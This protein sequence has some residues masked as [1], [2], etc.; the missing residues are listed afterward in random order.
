M[1]VTTRV[2]RPFSIT[3]HP[4]L[5]ARGLVSCGVVN[6][7][8]TTSVHPLPCTLV[9]L[10]SRPHPRNGSSTTDVVQ[11]YIEH[12]YARYLGRAAYRLGTAYAQKTALR[13][14]TN[15]ANSYFFPKKTR[16]TTR[17]GSRAQT[18]M[19]KRIGYGRRS[20]YGARRRTAYRRPA[21]R[22]RSARRTGGSR[23]R[24][25]GVKSRLRSGRRAPGYGHPNPR[26]RARFPRGYGSLTLRRNYGQRAAVTYHPAIHDANVVEP[27]STS[28]LA[29]VKV[30]GTT[31]DAFHLFGDAIIP[32]KTVIGG[33]GRDSTSTSVLFHRIR[34]I[35]TTPTPA[36]EKE[37]EVRWI[38]VRRNVEHDQS[39]LWHG[40]V[41][42]S[43]VLFLGSSWTNQRNP[44]SRRAWTIIK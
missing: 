24:W 27:G 34:L 17:Q 3:T 38:I 39:P 29:I 18:R 16:G 12:P 10:T 20:R 4:F 28:L 7:T 8:H 1:V 41:T 36:A 37:T 15:T 40:N 13:Y 9:N 35:V 5:Y 19:P 31:G 11:S 25:T 14:A 33:D 43:N 42:D 2:S 21:S 44:V 26:P 32:L 23:R 22:Y 30:T 6:I